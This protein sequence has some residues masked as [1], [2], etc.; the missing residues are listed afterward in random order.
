MA[1]PAECNGC[2]V[3]ATASSVVLTTP[4]TPSSEK[5]Q[6]IT[7]A[8]C[9][10]DPICFTR[11][12]ARKRANQNFNRRGNTRC[13]NHFETKSGVMTNDQLPWTLWW[14]NASISRHTCHCLREFPAAW[15]ARK[16]QWL[17]KWW[18]LFVFLDGLQNTCLGKPFCCGKL[19]GESPKHPWPQPGG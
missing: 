10:N 18:I 3:P 17:H 15:A 5:T 8:Y 6:N 2:L 12:R 14:R 1:S 13:C 4:A 7:V 16:R 19:R 9:S 11:Q